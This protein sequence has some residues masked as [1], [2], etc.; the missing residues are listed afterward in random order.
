MPAIRILGPPL[1]SALPS[2]EPVL[3][4]LRHS[5]W[6]CLLNASSDDPAVYNI[7]AT[8]R[9]A[10]KWAISYSDQLEN[11]QRKCA[12]LCYNRFIQPNSFCNY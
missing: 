4:C 1:T 9:E 11:I 2:L 8:V 5:D 3:Y 10:I 7:T 12:N 6:S